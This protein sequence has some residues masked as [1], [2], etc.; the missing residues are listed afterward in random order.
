M[1]KHL[2]KLTRCVAADILRDDWLEIG[3]NMYRVYKVAKTRFYN[4]VVIT[5]WNSTDSPADQARVVIET[6]AK[7]VFDVYNQ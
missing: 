3:G 4:G 6:P 1:D 7:V 5:L 2:M